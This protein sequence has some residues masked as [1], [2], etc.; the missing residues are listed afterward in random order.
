MYRTSPPREKNRLSIEKV[1]F[2]LSTSINIVSK[3]K[4]FVGRAEKAFVRAVTL[5]PNFRDAHF[6]LAVLYFTKDLPDAKKAGLHYFKSIELGG[7]RSAEIENFLKQA[8]A[9]SALGAR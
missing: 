7:E 8:E 5:E 4:G 1:S 6:N 9:A 2:R 3:E